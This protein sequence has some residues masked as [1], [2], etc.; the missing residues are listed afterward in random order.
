M[1]YSCSVYVRRTLGNNWQVTYADWPNLFTTMANMFHIS[2]IEPALMA[3]FTS[4]LAC[5]NTCTL[6]DL[7]AATSDVINVANW[8][9]TI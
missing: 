7:I 8:A 2:T 5:P 9:A 1:Y 6:E 4:C 3:H